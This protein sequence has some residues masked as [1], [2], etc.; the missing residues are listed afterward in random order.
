MS[1]IP[2]TPNIP[3]RKSAPPR[4]SKPSRLWLELHGYGAVK[5]FTRKG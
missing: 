1:Y 4:P 3:P 5:T 2:N